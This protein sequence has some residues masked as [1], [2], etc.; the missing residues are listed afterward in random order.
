M[1]NGTQPHETIDENAA[2][3]SPLCRAFLRQDWDRIHPRLAEWLN[4]L[5]R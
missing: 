4:V 1:E 3:I 5:K 2:T